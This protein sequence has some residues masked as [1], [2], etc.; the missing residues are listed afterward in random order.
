MI[1]IFVTRKIP[2][3][4]LQKLRS[5][6]FDVS[7]SSKERPLTKK[8]LIKE[9][10]KNSYE[11][12]LTLLT[13]QIDNEVV[14]AMKKSGIKAISQFAV[15]FNNIDVEYAQKKGII[16][17][18]TPASSSEEVAEHTTALMMSLNM[19]ILPMDTFVRKGKYKGW[20]PQLLRGPS[21]KGK[22]LGII[23][24]GNIGQYT[25]KIA[26]CGLN[27]HII[28][29]DLHQNKKIEMA[30][31]GVRKE[32]VEDVLKEADII[33]LH[34]PLNEH[35]HHLINKENI[36]LM[37]K[38]ALLINTS[39]G[40][41]IDEAVLVSALK[42]KRIRGAALDVF[43]HEPK[44]AKG[45]SKLDNVILTPHIGSAT[46]INREEMAHISTQNL[47]HFFNGEHLDNK[48]N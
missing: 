39:R 12:V 25:A 42:E 1:K 46:K 22:T 5:A 15:G 35:T 47:I 28:Y 8:E 30:L 32:S 16:V 27:M 26:H 18:N 2:E 11:A 36:K 9:F 14:D 44:L 10:A 13:D 17:M 34:V 33:S 38:T 31:N 37:K 40:A 48:I 23:G 3:S 20:D 41:V 24:V 21:L 6:G 29:F 4:G 19:N 43:E 7:I 45:L